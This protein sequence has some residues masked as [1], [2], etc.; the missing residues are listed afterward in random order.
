MEGDSLIW[1]GAKRQGIL[2]ICRVFATQPDEM[3]PI[4]ECEVIFES[5]LRDCR[6]LH[7]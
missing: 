6:D 7:D 3:I 5:F 4:P 2:N 1:Q